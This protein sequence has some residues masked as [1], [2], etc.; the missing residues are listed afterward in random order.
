[1]E[2]EKV[3]EIIDRKTSIP[4]DCETTDF[5]H[6][7]Y[8]MASKIIDKAIPK[9]IIARRCWKCEHDDCIV[10]CEYNFNRCPNCKEVLDT[11][12]EEQYKYCPDCGQALL[13]VESEE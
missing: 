12:Y 9:H 8:D 2:I 1:M 11:D 6:E 13:W 3:K 7:A 5:I 4:L 10:G